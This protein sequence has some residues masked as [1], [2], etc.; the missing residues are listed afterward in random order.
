MSAKS[1]PL[2][3]L[4]IVLAFLVD[5][6]A[7]RA[8]KLLACEPDPASFIDRRH[9]HMSKLIEATLRGADSL[10][11]GNRSYDAPTG[12]YVQIIVSTVQQ[13]AASTILR[14]APRS[15]CRRPISAFSCFSSK[16]CP[17]PGAAKRNATR[18]RPPAS[19][20]TI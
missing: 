2:R 12:S 8:E 18:K 7:V 10:F 6:G 13:G 19:S 20:R 15:T 16:T 3:C 1:A 9:D 17:A 5:A 11:S 14:R 4:V